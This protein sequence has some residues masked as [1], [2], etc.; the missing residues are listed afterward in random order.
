MKIKK[1]LQDFKKYLS[2]NKACIIFLFLICSVIYSIRL[3]YINTSIDSEKI[4][5]NY[6]EFKIDW[7]SLGR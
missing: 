7:N 4:I 1:E 6:N 3:F 5:N 2:N